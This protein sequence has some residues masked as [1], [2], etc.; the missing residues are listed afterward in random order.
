[1]RMPAFFTPIRFRLTLWYSAILVVLMLVLLLGINLAMFHDRPPR[2]DQQ[3]PPDVP[4]EE[5]LPIAD[6]SRD[7]WKQ[8]MATLR[9][10]S[11]IGMG[12]ILVVS[13]RGSRFADPDVRQVTLHGRVD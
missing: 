9:R 8:N 1:M 13:A 5:P 6:P 12:V 11:F 10:N 7:Q 3:A 2:Q 4:I